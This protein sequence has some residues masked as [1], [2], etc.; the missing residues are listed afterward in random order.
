M[1]RL[2]L[3][4]PQPRPGLTIMVPRG[5]EEPPKAT[6]FLCGSDFT[7]DTALIRHA[8]TCVNDAGHDHRMEREE[9]NARLEIFS[10]E[11]WDPEVSAHLRKVGQQM[12][13]EGRWEVKPNERAGFS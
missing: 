12:L 13:K 10:E 11:A 5:Y 3:P 6:C 1:S 7:S 4:G 9:K 8:K 2:I